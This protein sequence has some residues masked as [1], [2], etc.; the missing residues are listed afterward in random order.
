[1]GS[2]K[3][4]PLVIFSALVVLAGFSGYVIVLMG[5]E[6]A[7]MLRYLIRA[8]G[9]TLIC[10]LS[11]TLAGFTIWGGISLVSRGFV[12]FETIKQARQQTATRA[13]QRRK[14]EAEVRKLEREAELTI[15]TSPL[16]YQV[17]IS[18]LNPDSY[19]QARHL[20]ARVYANGPQSAQPPDP[21]ELGLWLA[22][23]NR[24][25]AIKS[26]AQVVNPSHDLT[27]GISL[28]DRIDLTDLL[29]D[30]R[31]TLQNIILGVRL[32]EYGQLKT[33]SAPMY[34][35]CH[36]GAA[37][38]TDSGKSNFGRV[39]AYQI[40][41]AADDVHVVISDLKG[42]TFK[43]FAQSERLLYPI[44]HTPG[45]FTAVIA[46]LR[47][48]MERRKAQF[49]PYPTVETL[50]DYNQLAETRLPIIVVFVDEITNLF[51]TKEIQII[52]LE[53]LREARAFG[54]Y[55]MAMGQSWSHREMNTSIRQQ[56]RTGMHFGTNDPASSRM[57]VNNSDAVRIVVP[58]RALASLPFGMSAGAVEV[59]TPYLDSGS[60]IEALKQHQPPVATTSATR[61]VPDVN[62]ISLMPDAC[63][64]APKPTA[65][66]ARILELWD[67]GTVDKKTISRQV[68]GR[69]GGA[70]YRLIEATLTKFGRI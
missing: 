49:K 36:I 48:E 60:A 9:L 7:L 22:A 8:S 34:R 46:E 56:F 42:T 65:K 35:L 12:A 24:Q 13:L 39:V 54:I 33:I 14:A 28:P 57:I 47:A 64:P 25:S 2:D 32:D 66:Q 40:F 29:P 19:W 52:T 21:V 31:G 45:E 44:I 18:D 17:H 67:S 55:F 43:P 10:G 20:E 26:P 23:R 11:L 58:G 51:M 69:I 53:M 15:V 37:G 41:T 4:T 16:D 1:M 30:M 38:A 3:V 5:A 63:K 27:S 62:S 61:P 70:Q 6:L 68:Y 59:Q 50:R